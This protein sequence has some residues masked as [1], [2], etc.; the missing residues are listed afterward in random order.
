[1]AVVIDNDKYAQIAEKIEKR[2]KYER[3]GEFNVLLFFLYLFTPSFIFIV[4]SAIWHIELG[5]YSSLILGLS[6]IV[7]AFAIV[8]FVQKR[9]REYPIDDTEWA[10]YYTR[11]LYDNLAKYIGTKPTEAGIRKGYRKKVLKNAEGLLSCAQ[12][13]WKVGTFKP[14]KEF[15]KGTVSDF[16]ENLQYRIIPAVKDGD[17]LILKNVERIIYNFLSYA[18]TLHIEDIRSLNERMCA[19]DNTGLPNR[20]P[21]KTSYS[22]R[23]GGYVKS[24]RLAQHVLAGGAIGAICIMFGYG[25]FIWGV[26]RESVIGDT[27]ILFGILMGGYVAI[28]W[29]RNK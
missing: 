4:I 18:Q 20:K 21:L 25:I 5:N 24:H 23:F 17:D 15:E 26:S 6:G 3:F 2:L 28:Q 10:V 8:A 16:A 27:L 19:S 14:I 1:M 12:E 7:L 13:R 11:P 29:G 22:S 9:L